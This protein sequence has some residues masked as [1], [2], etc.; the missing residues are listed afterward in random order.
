VIEEEH[1]LHDN[2]AAQSERAERKAVYEDDHAS[3]TAKRQEEVRQ[4]QIAAEQYE[5]L[6]RERERGRERER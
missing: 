5:R 2:A 4:Q 1:R 6:Q 3:V